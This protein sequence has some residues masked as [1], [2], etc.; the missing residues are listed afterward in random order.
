M[1]KK[2]QKAFEFLKSKFESQEQFSKKEFEA[3][4]K[5]GKSLPTYWSKKINTLLI[6]TG[7]S[8]RVSEVFRRYLNPNA[9]YNHISQTTQVS[10][11]YLS[12]S[13]ENVIL[14]D[15]FMPLSNE[16]FLRDVLD[17]LFY[18]D[19][20]RRRLNS[21]PFNQLESK[22]PESQGSSNDEMIE[23][24]C[25]FISN[26]FGGYS[27][28][29]VSGRFRADYL[30]SY[31]EVAKKLQKNGY[32]Y[33]ID[34]TTAIIRFIFPCGK[35]KEQPFLSKPNYFE[36]FLLRESEEDIETE[37]EKIRWLFYLLFVQ[38]IIEMI[39]GEDEIWM[40]ESGYKNRLHIWRMEEKI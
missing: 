24:L 27:I 7:K 22:F 1:D 40:L 17:S 39:N 11:N 34:E 12:Y 13:Y 19:S 32:K 6:K 30:Q 31:M 25:E 8:F 36:E 3:E 29:H 26:K 20:I 21:I 2:Q 10:Q 4:V 33:L 28:S 9:F 35:K 18:K 15:F 38:S 14:F 16:L 23:E 37:A 5:W